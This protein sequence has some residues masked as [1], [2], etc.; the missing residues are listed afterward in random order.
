M[1][2]A[3]YRLWLFSDVEARQIYENLANDKF[4]SK[5]SEKIDINDEKWS[6]SCKYFKQRG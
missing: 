2:F 5:S 3:V 6:R 4:E 1:A